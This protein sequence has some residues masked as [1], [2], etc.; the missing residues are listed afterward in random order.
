M[1]RLFLH[2][3]SAG[4]R[5]SAL[6]VLYIQEE[7]YNNLYN[8]IKEDTE[9]LKI[10]DTTDFSNDVGAVIDRKSFDNLARHISYM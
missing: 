7:I 9:I 10:G 4:Q 8:L 2:F 6:R 3:I 5:Y 1:M